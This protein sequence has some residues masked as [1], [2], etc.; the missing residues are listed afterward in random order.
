MVVVETE[1]LLQG[2]DDCCRDWMIVAGTGWLL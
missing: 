1:W 2:L